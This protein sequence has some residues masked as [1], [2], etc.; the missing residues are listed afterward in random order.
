M[1]KIAWIVGAFVSIFVT[2][3]VMADQLV[4][5][6]HTYR[7]GYMTTIN[8][9][10]TASCIKAATNISNLNKHSS[11][12][13]IRNNARYSFFKLSFYCITEN[14]DVTANGV[15]YQ[16]PYSSD[17]KLCLSWSAW[18][19]YSFDS[20]LCGTRIFETRAVNVPGT[21]DLH[22][23]VNEQYEKQSAK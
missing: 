10:D 12:V 20:N 13:L 21:A 6:E 3:S 1:R 14:G 2:N 15:L 16:L 22:K 8:T 7:E 5:R 19:G 18:D 4:I 11:I 23:W 9:I 17:N